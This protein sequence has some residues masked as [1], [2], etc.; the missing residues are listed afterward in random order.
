MPP[1]SGYE[2]KGP[3]TRG[4]KVF[5]AIWIAVAVVV[6]GAVVLYVR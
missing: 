2:F 6:L 3:S 4:E 5:T 1:E